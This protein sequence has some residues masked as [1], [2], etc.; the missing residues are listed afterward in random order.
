[1][2]RYRRAFTLLEL[3]IA[4]S[5][6]AVIMVSIYTAFRSGIFSQRAIETRID[7]YQTARAVL[8]Q[9]DKDLRNC[10]AYQ[11][12]NETA[13]FNGTATEVDFLTLVDAYRT[14]GI[15][16]ECAR[17]SYIFEAATDPL[18]N[19]L[20]RRSRSNLDAFNDESDVQPEE[21]AAGAALGL[22]YGSLIK[23]EEDKGLQFKDSWGHDAEG[24]K[25]LPQAVE[26]SLTITV[27]GRTTEQ[28]FKRTIYLPL[29][30]YES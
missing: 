22:R 20:M 24:K 28:K 3:M 9:I 10:F 14:E 17:I 11:D 19:R 15:V 18:K 21:M 25:K 13:Q 26:V 30:R 27:P 23:G 7:T 29:A 6:F 1:M 2:M 4:S 8:E 12:K 5:V 16:P